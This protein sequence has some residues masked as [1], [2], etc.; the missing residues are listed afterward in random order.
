MNILLPRDE[1]QYIEFESESVKAMEL[2]EEIVAF[3]NGEGGEIWLGVE[4]DGTVSGLSRSY[5]EDVMNIC[6]TACIPPIV[7]R[8][9][10]LDIGG[11]QVGHIHIPRGKDK[12]YYTSRQK[13]FVRVGSTKRV[14]AREEL[15]RPFQASGAI[16]YDLV[17]VDRAAVKDLDL[18][19]IGTFFARYNISF[20]DEPEEERVR[21]MTHS[22]MLGEGGHPTLAGL[23]VFGLA[24]ERFLTQSGIL[25]AHFDG[26]E[27][28]A[29]LIDKKAILGPLTRQVEHGLAAIKATSRRFA[30]H[31]GQA[32]G[33]AP[34]SR[35]GFSRVAGQCLCASQLQPAWGPDTGLFV[36]R[37]DGGYKSRPASQHGEHREAIRGY[38]FCQKPRSRPTHGKPGLRG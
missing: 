31:W 28:A 15:I 13:Y 14:A 2:L 37:P 1:N 22:D 27:L 17:E 36:C 26:H 7:P 33:G 6:R 20:F 23:L 9:E 12:P 29:D 35:P 38:E 5:E 16:H 30:H 24:P 3:A 10:A 8:Y 19:Q 21:L 18:G 25:L 34:L 11:K 32:R 4:D